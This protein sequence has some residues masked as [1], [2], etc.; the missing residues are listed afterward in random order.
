MEF[1]ED[2]ALIAQEHFSDL[3]MFVQNSEQIE[4][5]SFEKDLFNRLLKIGNILMRLYITK[6]GTGNIGPNAT[7]EK[8]DKLTHYGQKVTKMVSIFGEIDIPREYY[9]KKGIGGI[10]PLDE[11]LNLSENCY[12]YFLQR[13]C[14]GRFVKESFE[15][16]RKFI[17]ETFG[18]DLPQSS[19]QKIAR[20]SSKNFEQYYKEKPLIN[21][22]KDDLTIVSADG[23]GIPMKRDK[24]EN[25]SAP[26]RLGKGEK[27]TRKQMSL[28]GTVFNVKPNFEEK[29]RKFESKNKK[30]W[31][32]LSDKIK[33]MELLQHDVLGRLKDNVSNTVI[34]LADGGRDLWNLK[35]EYFPN[36]IEILDWFHMTEYLWKA[37]YVFFPEGSK[38]A[39]TWVSEMERK[40]LNNKV[41]DVITGLNVRKT[42][43]NLKGKRLKTIKSVVKYF[44]NNKSRMQYNDYRSKGYPIGSGCIEGACRYLV[45]DRM[46]MTGMRWK[47]KGAQA[48][49]SLRS[50][51]I[52][53]D[54]NGYWEYFMKME[55]LRLY[56]NLKKTG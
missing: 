40:M 55:K 28:V 48:V 32:F 51:Y 29:N 17:S 24:E 47:V 22:E 8:G 44:Q 12:S 23:K 3:L 42:K 45:K 53:G 10:F 36:A 52:N 26:K 16:T 11:E 25:Y 6:K 39:E 41:A 54:L 46:E 9:Y 1:V 14:A 21:I 4:P 35:N 27:I 5:Y 2:Y 13:F 7:L 18:V 34:F 37:V 50:A 38:D 33:T 15:E 31:A 43:L 19:I 30:T 20:N 56:P 49:L